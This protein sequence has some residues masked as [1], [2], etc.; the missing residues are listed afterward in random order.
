MTFKQC[1][2]G[3]TQ[4]CCPPQCIL[5]AQLFSRP[6]PGPT[7]DALGVAQDGVN[8]WL[9]AFLKHIARRLLLNHVFL[10][11]DFYLRIKAMLIVQMCKQSANN[12]I[13][14]TPR[15]GNSPLGNRQ[16][17]EWPF[18]MVDLV[19]LKSQPNSEL[20]KLS[21]EQNQCIRLGTW[22]SLFHGHRQVVTVGLIP[23]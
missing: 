7:I 16:R 19:L 11:A 14:G 2:L 9:A 1:H 17:R 6:R 8:P 10:W 12:R 4:Q 20:P 21:L 5:G 15:S 3:I 18:S 13:K 22:S 23:I